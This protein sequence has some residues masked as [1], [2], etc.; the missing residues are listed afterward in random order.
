MTVVHHSPADREDRDDVTAGTEACE[1]RQTEKCNGKT[2][3]RDCKRQLY[4]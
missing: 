4:L 2:H 3:C 1:H